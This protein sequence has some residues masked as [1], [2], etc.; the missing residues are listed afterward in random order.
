M[1]FALDPIQRPK[2]GT[3][4]CC[5]RQAQSLHDMVNDVAI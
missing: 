2:E 3:D 4:P 5:D 1:N